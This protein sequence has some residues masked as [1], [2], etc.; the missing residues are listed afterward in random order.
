MATEGDLLQHTL[1]E[2]LRMLN[3]FYGWMVDADD[4]KSGQVAAVVLASGERMEFDVSGVGSDDPRDRAIAATIV[5]LVTA[6]EYA[7][8]LQRDID[9][10]D[11]KTAI[12]LAMNAREHLNW[13]RLLVPAQ[14]D[15]EQKA[16]SN[17][18][19][20]KGG[21]ASAVATDEEWRLIVDARDAMK[22]SKATAAL[23]I[24]HQL[25][26]GEFPGIDRSIELSKS[27]IRQKKV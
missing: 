17:S 18:G 6:H 11:V 16:R 24:S 3:R 20:A 23:R 15:L 8:V 22:A 27:Q 4:R 19:R 2:S 13:G 9:T 25:Y 1:D 26:L 12:N 5:H 21:K 10:I 14:F 7:R